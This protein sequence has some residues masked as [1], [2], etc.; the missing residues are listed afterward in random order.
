MD[1]RGMSLRHPSC[2]SVSRSLLVISLTFVE[3]NVP[4]PPTCVV[5][6]DCLSFA[7]HH[8]AMSPSFT[9]SHTRNIAGSGGCERRY[10]KD[11]DFKTQSATVAY[12]REQQRRIT[13]MAVWETTCA[14]RDDHRFMLCALIT[15]AARQRASGRRPLPTEF[16][17]RLLED[18]DDDMTPPPPN[19][20]SP[21]TKQASDPYIGWLEKVA[22]M[23]LFAPR[24]SEKL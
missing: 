3:T 7:P 8:T 22:S 16:V 5:T 1:W 23:S 20:S 6:M 21:M 2:S 11:L 14:T 4:E 13:V 15:E 17:Q 12:Q 18:I 9:V 24:S 10:R 19:P